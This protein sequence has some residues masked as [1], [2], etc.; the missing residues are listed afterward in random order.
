[1]S[2]TKKV[3][4]KEDDRVPSDS[5]DDFKYEEV[6]LDDD[7][8]L[9]EGEED[10]EATVKAIKDRAEAKAR[11]APSRTTHRAQ[12]VD[13]FLRNF[14]FQAGMTET[15]DC[16]QTEWTEMVQKGLVNAESVDVVPDV[17]IENQRLESELKIAEREREQYKLA[18]S[19]AA[20]TLGRVQR[21]RDFH[22]MQHNRVVQEK[23]RLIE[24]MRKL[25]AQCNSYEP[26]VK[27]MNDKYEAVLRQTMLVTLDRDK[28]LSQVNC[29]SAQH[30]TLSHSDADEENINKTGVRSVKG[31]NQPAKTSYISRSPQ[32]PD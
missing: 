3:Q 2:A 32:N 6:S 7:W 25:K 31:T 8:S 9:L 5:E 23:N 1:M 29:Q 18:A 11:A 22:R 20:E 21:A 16:F 15:L 26:V 17:H 12:T 27:R 4:E 14:L 19:A 24:E 28:A 13:V 10:L 30:N